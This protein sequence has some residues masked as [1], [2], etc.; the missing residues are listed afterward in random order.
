MNTILRRIIIEVNI[1][2][3]VFARTL[4]YSIPAYINTGYHNAFHLL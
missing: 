2:L 4:V 1:Y 3:N